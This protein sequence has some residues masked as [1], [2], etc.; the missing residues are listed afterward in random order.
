MALLR[1]EHRL[2]PVSSC[3]TW[4]MG[5]GEVAARELMR[6]VVSCRDP[7]SAMSISSGGMV[8][9][10]MLLTQHW[11]ASFQLYVLTSIESDGRVFMLVFLGVPDFFFVCFH[12]DVEFVVGSDYGLVE[13][14]ASVAEVAFE[15]V[16]SE[17]GVEWDEE[18][19]GDGGGDFFADDFGVGVPVEFVEVACDGL[20]EVLH[21]ELVVLCGDVFCWSVDCWGL[22]DDGGP[23]ASIFFDE[24]E[25]V[26][27]V[28]GF[29]PLSEHVVFA[30]DEYSGWAV[31]GVGFLVEE[32][33]EFFWYYFVGVDYEHVGVCCGLDGEVACWLAY[34]VVSF[35]EGDDFA[36]EG[37]RYVDGV[38]GA[39]HVADDYFVEYFEVFEDACEV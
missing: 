9:L 32:V 39:L 19:C 4:I 16:Y 21:G 22:V 27:G 25:L 31:V 11:S 5:T 24:A 10:R 12:D 1:M 7:S 23:V 37:L 18:H 8:C 30:R 3:H 26:V 36:A 6:L 38:V 33:C 14:D 34:C 28:V 35:R 15:E 17:E 2:N 20:A 29:D 13:S